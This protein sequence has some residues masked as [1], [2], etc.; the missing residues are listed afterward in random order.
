MAIEVFW[1]SGSP[2]SWRVLLA[3]EIKGLAYSSRLLQRSEREHKTPEF[4]A[5]NPRGQV[6]VLRDGDTV[7]YES[8]A[9]LAYLDR[10]A[11]SPP[12]FGT[13]PAEAGH[14]WQLICEQIAYLD[15][16]ADDFILPLYFG[17]SEERSAQVSAAIPIIAKE[18]ARAEEG[19]RGRSWRVGDAISAGDISLFPTVKSL[20]RAAGKPAAGAFDHGLTPFAQRY[21]ALAQWCARIEALPGYERTVP[22]HWR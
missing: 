14:I 15:E 18:L 20:L 2:F 6:P 13:N 12:L 4:L 16:I 10:K 17:Q 8:I 11:P 22:P 3:L 9:I 5:M 21:P 19:L 1:I 7:I